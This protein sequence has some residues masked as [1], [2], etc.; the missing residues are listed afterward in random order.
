MQSSSQ[1]L[2]SIVTPAHNEAEYLAECIESVLAQ[3]YQN[4]EYTIVD[5]CSSDGSGEIAAGYAAKDQRIRVVRNPELLRAI[6]NFNATLRLISPQSRYC[7]VVFGDDLI[8][9]ECLERMVAAGETHP[10][11]GIISAYALEGGKVMCTGLAY[12]CDFLTG[13]ETCRRHL[14]EKLFLW[15]SANTVMYRADLVRSHNPFYNEANIH[16][17]TEVCFELLKESDLAFVHQVLT[18]TRTRPGSLSTISTDMSTYLASTLHVLA[19]HGAGFLSPE[20]VDWRM[21]WHLSDYYRALGK[22]LVLGR[23]QKFWSYH[24]SQLV[25]AGVGYSRWQVL[26]GAVLEMGRAALSPKR[27]VEKLWKK[28]ESAQPKGAKSAAAAR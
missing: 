11:A 25:E 28:Q 10:T 6:P 2:V 17:D 27:S 18:F 19:R 23:D 3:T 12:P 9:P 16:S 22:A 24:K 13:R 4:W 26:K 7:K 21:K 8:F 1:P 15:G 14:L 20:E 5:N